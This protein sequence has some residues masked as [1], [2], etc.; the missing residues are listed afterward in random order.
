MKDLGFGEQG[1]RKL[2]Q[3]NQSQYSQLY[4]IPELILLILYEK[5]T[6]FIILNI[7]EREENSSTK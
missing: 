6:F 4:N 2:D 7:F 1:R 3:W 5:N